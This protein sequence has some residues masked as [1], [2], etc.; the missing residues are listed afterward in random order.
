MRGAMTLEKLYIAYRICERSFG[1]CEWS[2]LLGYWMQFMAKA[3]EKLS[4]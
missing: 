3:K 2:I 4:I 1:L